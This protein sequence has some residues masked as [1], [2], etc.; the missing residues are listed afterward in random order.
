MIGIWCKIIVHT[1]ND[2]SISSKYTN[3][4]LNQSEHINLTCDQ[5]INS[6]L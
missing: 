1:V 5:S 3:I 6:L 2:I 4:T